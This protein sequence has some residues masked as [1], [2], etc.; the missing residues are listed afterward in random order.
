MLLEKKN[1][2]ENETERSQKRQ[3][4]KGKAEQSQLSLYKKSPFTRENKKYSAEARRGGVGWQAD[5]DVD[6]RD[7]G[8]DSDGEADAEDTKEKLIAHFE[9]FLCQRMTCSGISDCQ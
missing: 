4:Q 7:D 5:F 8:S 6:S 2:V 1:T 9:T 3:R